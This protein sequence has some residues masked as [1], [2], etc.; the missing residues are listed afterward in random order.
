MSLGS[1]Y[2]EMEEFYTIFDLFINI[3]KATTA[4]TKERK[5]KVLIN[6]KPLYDKCFDTYKKITIVKRKNTKKK[7][8]VTINS[9]K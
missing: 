9:L 8:G 4:E 1:K 5:D 3:Y 2:D 7:E 6:F